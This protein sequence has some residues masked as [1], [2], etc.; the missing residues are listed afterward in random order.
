MSD[1]GWLG[2]GDGGGEKEAEHEECWIG[3]GLHSFS[4]S[5]VLQWF[6]RNF[7]GS[8]VAQLEPQL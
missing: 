3:A 8:S 6:F 4:G 7:S 1:G 5:V 2:D